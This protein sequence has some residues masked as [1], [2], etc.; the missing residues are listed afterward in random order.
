[1]A[2]LSAIFRPPGLLSQLSSFWGP[3]HN[4]ATESWF[5]S[6]KNERIFGE[7]FATLE[8][9]KASAF[10]YI[11][12]FYNRRRLHSTLGYTSPLQFLKNWSP[13]QQEE[14]LVA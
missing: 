10:E 9:M 6:F 8:A 2:P 11:E 1:M 4:A 12:M 14:H 13:A 7:R 3:L 5:N